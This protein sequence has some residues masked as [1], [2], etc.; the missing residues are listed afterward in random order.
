MPVMCEIGLS[1]LAWEGGLSAKA[2]A[3]VRALNAN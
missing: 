2:N 3:R 1:I